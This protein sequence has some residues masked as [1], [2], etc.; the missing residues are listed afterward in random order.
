MKTFIFDKNGITKN[1]L[2]LPEVFGK[3]VNHNL[4]KL[5]V[6]VYLGNQR[7]SNAQTK[8]RGEV[9]GSGKKMYK[10][11]GTGNAR[12]GAI[13]SPLMRKGGVVFGPSNNANHKRR[14]SVSQRKSAIASA[15]SLFATNNNVYVVDDMSIFSEN[16]A[17]VSKLLSSVFANKYVN[18]Y[19]L[20]NDDLIVRN[21]SN[22][23]RSEVNMLD[24]INVYDIL[25]SDIVLLDVKTLEVINNRY[26]I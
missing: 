26:N 12:R 2:E 15:L 13:R 22:L 4:M 17:A 5:A 21:F 1:Q 16:T 8:D 24:T 18:L 9:S 23:E 10:Q 7:E 14:L 20:D 19:Q 11:K 6:D 3:K 25:N